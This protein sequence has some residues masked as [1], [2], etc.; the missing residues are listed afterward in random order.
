MTPERA[1]P[2]AAFLALARQRELLPPAELDDLSR[3]GIL[4]PD[5]LDGVIGRLMEAGTLTAAEVAQLQ[6]PVV[7]TD[8]APLDRPQSD[9]LAAMIDD[10][11]AG[12]VGGWPS[13]E[14]EE[15]HPLGRVEEMEVL[16]GDPPVTPEEAFVPREYVPGE[17]GDA[18]YGGVP[19][20]PPEGHADDEPAPARESEPVV[21]R[22]QIWLWVGL[23]IGLQLLAL[24][25]WLVYFFNPFGGSPT[26]APA[27]T[28]TKLPRKAT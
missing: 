22:N 4:T 23:A 27:P 11:L 17:S 12:S 26:P 7:V 3:P 6:T 8:P 2:A 20:V 9:A 5:R 18:V 1:D 10:A 25:L 16:E 21:P 13:P 14:P 15:L 28:P 19:Y 24:V